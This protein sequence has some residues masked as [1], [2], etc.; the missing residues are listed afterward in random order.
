MM[1]QPLTNNIVNKLSTKNLD[2]KQRRV[3]NS[4]TSQDTNDCVVQSE[5]TNSV[6][7]LQSSID[8]VSQ[9]L[10]NLSSISKPFKFLSTVVFTKLV[11]FL[12]GIIVNL[13]YPSADSTTAIKITKADGITTVIDIDTTNGRIGVNQTPNNAALDIL[14][15]NPFGL[16]IKNTNG[17]NNNIQL[18]FYGANAATDTWA[19]G[20]DLAL[21]NGSKDFNFYD[22]TMNG[23][24]LTLVQG[25]G[26]SVNGTINST[27]VYKSNGVAGEAGPV[28]ITYLTGTPAAGQSSKTITFNGGI[29]TAHT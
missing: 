19:L 16:R 17:A 28:T 4:A 27:G 24:L 5:L 7:N 23:V 25:T 12:S 9:K 14:S 2:M 3:I 20:T 21:G 6:T 11:T 15:T 13:I 10:I 8:D 18:R 26:I 29:E 1:N 22:L